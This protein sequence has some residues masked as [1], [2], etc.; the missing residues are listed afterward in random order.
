M[1]ATFE[2]GPDSAEDGATLLCTT[3]MPKRADGEESRVVAGCFDVAYNGYTAVPRMLAF[4][5]TTK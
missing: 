2:L 1:F 4:T 3:S 5:V